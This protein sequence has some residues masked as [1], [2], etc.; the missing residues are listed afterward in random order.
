[1]KMHTMGWIVP[2][3]MLAGSTLAGPGPEEQL[4]GRWFVRYDNEN[5]TVLVLRARSEAVLEVSGAP[6]RAGTW[7]LLPGE[8]PAFRL[9]LPGEP[10]II[11]EGRLETDGTLSLTAPGQGGGKLRMRR[12]VSAAEPAE[13]RHARPLGKG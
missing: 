7:E 6:D 5:E 13:V 3:L 2:A 9:T 10:V 8:L 11:L 4:I 12:K 1:M